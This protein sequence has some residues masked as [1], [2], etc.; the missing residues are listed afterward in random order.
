VNEVPDRSV[1]DHHAALGELAHEPPQREIGP[2]EASHKPN[3]LIA[4]DCLRPV[5]SHL[6]RRDTARLAH[7]PIPVDHSTDGD[8]ELCR[9]LAPGHP[10]RNRGHHALSKIQRIGST[11]RMLASNPASIL[12]HDSPRLGIPPI[13]PKVISL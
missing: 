6:A 4:G 11:H 7:P 3:A 13:Q 9:C 12:N 2:L 1:I 10:L 5:S 8:A